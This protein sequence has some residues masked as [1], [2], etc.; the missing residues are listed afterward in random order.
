MKNL[1][2]KVGSAALALLLLAGGASVARAVWDSTTGNMP[3]NYF[4]CFGANNSDCVTGNSAAHAVSLVV[5]GSTVLSGTPTGGVSVPGALAVTGA[6]TLTGNVTI[7]GT[8]AL[9]GALSATPPIVSTTALAATAYPIG[10]LLLVQ[11]SVAGALVTNAYN[12]GW[13]TANVVGSCVYISV[14][15]SVPAVAGANCKS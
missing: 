10:Q 8:T 11:E 1:A 3:N 15:T 2:K 12:L 9:T 5:N 7:T 14:S 4:L 6:S 13:S